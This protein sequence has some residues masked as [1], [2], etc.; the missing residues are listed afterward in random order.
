MCITSV[1]AAMREDMTFYEL[2]SISTGYRYGTGV[3][4]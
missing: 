4:T 2:T 1:A 3:S